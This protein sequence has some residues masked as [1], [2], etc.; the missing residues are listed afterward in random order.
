MNLSSRITAA[1]AAVI[2]SASA[3]SCSGK[4]GSSVSSSPETESSSETVATSET[5]SSADSSSTT[6]TV[7]TA[8]GKADETV[9]TTITT[10]TAAAEKTTEKPTEP[11]KAEP[12]KGFGSSF[13]AA[14]AYYNAYLT[15]NA[16]A[17]YDMFCQDEIEAYHAYIGTTDLLDGKNPQVV[18]KRSAVVDAIKQSMDNIRR[19]MSEKSDVPPEK[20]TTSLAED[21]LRPNG[22]NE[23]KDFNKTLSTEFTAGSDCGLIYY[24]DGNEEHDFVGN[25][26][27]FVE[28][29]G[30][31][32]LSYSSV[33]RSELITYMDKLFQ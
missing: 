24:K 18:F 5:A 14:K 31:W 4:T 8:S 19:I 21:S 16:D 25:G 9:T 23:L 29:D 17:V 32:Y 30:R 2:L 33:M 22:E 28:L 26:C 3:F 13:E 10:T 20:W 12:K 7:T 11:T 15:N 27:A 6:T 1:A